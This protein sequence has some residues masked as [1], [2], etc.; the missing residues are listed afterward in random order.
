MHLLDLGD[1]KEVVEVHRAEVVD[2]QHH[3]V[4]EDVVHIHVPQVVL[5]LDLVVVAVLLVPTVVVAR[6]PELLKEK[7][8]TV[9]I[10]QPM[11]EGLDQ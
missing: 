1:M 3:H 10:V 8:L 2:P 6:D 9:K 4:I 11:I 7:E 5:V